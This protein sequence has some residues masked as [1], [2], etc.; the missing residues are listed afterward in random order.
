M[1]MRRK[2]NV[3]HLERVT[4]KMALLKGGLHPPLQT[5]TTASQARP[6]LPHELRIERAG[7]LQL[8]HFHIS[9]KE[10]T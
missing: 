9:S 8:Y 4:A 10:K 5:T 1:M 2:E 6:F 7:T 3:N